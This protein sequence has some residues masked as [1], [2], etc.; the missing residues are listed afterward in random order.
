MSRATAESRGLALLTIHQQDRS[1]RTLPLHGE[2]Y[3]IR[4]DPDVEIRINHAT[5]C[6]LHALLWKQGRNWIL[7]DQGSTNGVWWQG[8]S[9]QQLNLQDGERI[10]FSPTQDADYP[11]IGF[12]Q[13]IHRLHQRIRKRLRIGILRC[14]GGA[15][16]FREDKLR[17]CGSLT[18]Y[19]QRGMSP[20]RQAVRGDSAD[21]MQALVRAV[22]RNGTSTAASLGGQE[23]GK[24][25]TTNE[26]RD[27]LF[28]G[29]EPSRRW[30]LGIWLG[31][32]D[33]SPSRSS[34]ALAASLWADIIR[35][36]GRG[37]LNGG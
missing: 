28:L 36:A 10:G 29:Y 19:D 27:Q 18:G 37:G 11:W 34:S 33:N 30:V 12:E 24:T 31:N 7:K 14:L 13:P 32:D 23:G 5:V 20:G 25:R 15:E 16:T 35:A 21:Q 26:G 22:V 8:R 1:E 2:S 3:W 6:R 17:G 4:R 9:V